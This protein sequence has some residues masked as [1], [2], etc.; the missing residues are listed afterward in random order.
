METAEE[1]LTMVRDQRRK[2]ETMPFEELAKLGE[3]EEV[4]TR[5]SGM[6][7]TVARKSNPDGSLSI[8]VEGWRPRFFGMYMLRTGDGFRITPSGHKSELK[9]QDWSQ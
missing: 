9:E 1:V 7:L 4:M 5:P 3:L 6:Q 8:I 2:L